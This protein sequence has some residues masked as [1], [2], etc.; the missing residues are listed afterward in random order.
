MSDDNKVQT[1]GIFVVYD[2]ECPF[3]SRYVAMLRLRE[4]GG[5]VELIDARSSHPMVDEVVDRGFDLDEGMVA[6]IG[7]AYYAGADCVNVLSLLSTRTNG[8]NCLNYW[9]FRSRSFSRILYPLLRFG[10]NLVLRL[11]GRTK[12]AKTANP[13][14]II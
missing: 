10:R 3:C 8:F 12:I 9:M 7:D 6:K 2:G 1:D 14:K 13:N 11:L 4:A 5:H